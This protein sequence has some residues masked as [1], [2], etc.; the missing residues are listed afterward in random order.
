M[1]LVYIDDSDPWFAEYD[2]CEKLFREIMEQLQLREREAKTSY[3][4]STLSAK[5]RLGM[6]QYTAEVQQLKVKVEEA[7]KSHSITAEEAERRTRQVEQLQSKDV[8]LQ[9]LYEP[10]GNDTARSTLMKSSTNFA[11]MGTTS[12]GIDDDDDQPLDV[13]ISTDELKTRQQQL[14]QEQE[15][16]LEELSKVIS[17]QKQIAHTIGNEVDH[18][19]EIIE[20]LADHMERT[21]ERL[22]SETRQ[23]RRIDRKD[24]TCSYWIV[25]ILL[26]ISI[27]TV[28]LV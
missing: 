3:A 28:A 7:W 9:R 14:L 25:I 1:A 12:W 10:R 2:A 16:G 4:Y 19:N 6:K 5:V 26:F 20:D 23:V 24:R 21:D 13:H 15:H 22:I 27:I 17:R 8:Q 18:Q 11:D